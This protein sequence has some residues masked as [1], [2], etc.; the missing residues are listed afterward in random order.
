[1]R[2]GLWRGFGCDL[3]VP[4]LLRVAKPALVEE[5]D[6]AVDDFVVQRIDRDFVAINHGPGTPTAVGWLPLDGVRLELPLVLLAHKAIGHAAVH[7]GK[8]WFALLR[9]AFVEVAHR[10]VAAE[11]K[12]VFVEVEARAAQR[13]R[14]V[15]CGRCGGRRRC[16]L[17]YD[18]HRWDRKNGK[19]DRSDR[20]KDRGQHAGVV[21][22][23]SFGRLRGGLLASWGRLRDSLVVQPRVQLQFQFPRAVA[24]L[25]TVLGV[26]GLIAPA[27]LAD[28]DTNAELHQLHRVLRMGSSIDDPTVWMTKVRGFVNFDTLDGIA[29]MFGNNADGQPFSWTQER[30]GPMAHPKATGAI[31]DPFA[32]AWNPVRN[33]L[34]WG[35][36]HG[37]RAD[38]YEALA[39]QAASDTL[40]S[41]R[42]TAGGA[43][44]NARID[45]LLFRNP[46]EGQGHVTV[47][48]RQNNE[49]PQGD[50]NISESLASP[51]YLDALVSSRDTYLARAFYSQS[52]L[53]DRLSFTVGKINP[54]DYVALN[55]FASD[56]TTQYLAQQ[57]DGNDVLPT[58]FQSYTPG[59]AVQAIATEWLTASA[60]FASADG[61]TENGFSLA[62]DTGYAVGAEANVLFELWDLPA[63][64]S[65]AWCGSDVGGPGAPSGVGST[66]LW[67]NSYAC[68]A[69]Y[70]VTERCGLFF[71]WAWAEEDVAG[72]STN[73]GGLGVTLDDVFGRVGDGAGLA[74]GW[75]EPTDPSLTT[76]GLLEAYYRMQVT[77]SLQVSLDVQVIL[78]PTTDELS[79]PTIVGGVR[80]VIRF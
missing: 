58:P 6:L 57:F 41:T 38:I 68:T 37:I 70:F 69:Q 22:S 67:G 18:E 79:E 78:P 29:P 5:V 17:L 27:A 1:M 10:V 3:R 66:D 42:S 39:W 31:G 47:Q 34:A 73:E 48:F 21:A 53:D 13:I 36:D 11:G 25:T 33:A 9:P 26:V 2:N 35:R 64:L 55:V 75:S 49:W 56:E 61:A 46:S 4:L 24:R 7:E 8:C 50:G 15:V 54:N 76:Q 63:R 51:V 16:A 52:M 72:T 23:F 74:V 44:F 77:G 62:L 20:E 60:F 40:P 43:R 14:N 45:A 12:A 32:F 59:V 19:S 80:A 71:Q 30:A 28:E 65:F